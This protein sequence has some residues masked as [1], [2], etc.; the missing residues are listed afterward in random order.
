MIYYIILYY[1]LMNIY[2][3]ITIVLLILIVIMYLTDKYINQICNNLEYFTYGKGSPTDKRILILGGIHGNEPAGSKAI[4]KFMNDINT[5][6]TSINKIVINDKRIIL[7]P[8]V[9]YCGLQM[10]MRA[11]PQIGDLNRKFPST[12]NYIDDD[13]NPI[14]K[15]I[16]IFVKEADIII[17]FHEGWGFYKEKNGSVGSTITP[18]NTETS[19]LIADKIYDNINKNIT[20]NNKKFTILIDESYDDNKIKTNPDKYG[21]NYDIKGTF[22]YYANLIKKNYLLIETSGQNDIQDLLTRTSQARVVIDTVLEN[23]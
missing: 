7:I 19:L 23:I 9:N 17:D 4:L 14:I 12:E 1:I 16:L 20:D 6:D 8:Y 2:I 13:L 11:M 18:T 22:R 10:N 5:N 21:K 15:K 3:I